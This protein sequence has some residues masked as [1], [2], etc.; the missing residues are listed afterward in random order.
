LLCNII[1]GAGPAAFEPGLDVR[2]ALAVIYAMSDVGLHMTG[3]LMAS[4][5]KE[6][7]RR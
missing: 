4:L 5:G 6:K 7:K 2:L 1:D 3:P